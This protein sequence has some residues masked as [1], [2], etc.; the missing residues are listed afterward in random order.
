MSKPLQ[1]YE[2]PGIAV[3]FDPRL[4]A[5]RHLRAGPASCLR[6]Q[7][8]AVDQ[9]RAGGRRA[10]DRTSGALPVGRVAVPPFAS[11]PRSGRL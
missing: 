1:T 8:E 4:S 3:T 7:A 5:H 2:G 11:G 9:A 10:C 6:R